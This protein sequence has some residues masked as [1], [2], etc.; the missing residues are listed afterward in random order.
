[1]C[2]DVRISTQVRLD[3][4]CGCAGF[5]FPHGLGL[6]CLGGCDVSEGEYVWIFT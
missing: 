4:V 6:G 3:W 2:G 5:M 1:M